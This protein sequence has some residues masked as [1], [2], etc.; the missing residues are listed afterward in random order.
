MNI[1]IQDAIANATVNQLLTAILQGDPDDPDIVVYINSPGG[2]IDASYAM[3]DILRLSGKH[4]I[5]FAVNEIFS[6][7]IVIYLAGDERFA[8][9]YSNFM[10]H[11]PF[12]EYGTDATVTKNQYQ[13]NLKELSSATQEYLSLISNRTKISVPKMKQYMAEAPQNEWFFKT[14]VAKK[15]GFVTKIGV[16]LF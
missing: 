5:T 12:H 16:P 1:F 11:E 15:Y 8:T 14:K 10:V 4:I 3:Y 9:N 6:C 13:R 7:A 2:E